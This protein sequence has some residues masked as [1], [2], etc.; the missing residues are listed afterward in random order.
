MIQYSLK[1]IGVV[2]RQG[3]M[4]SP[5]VFKIL[6]DRCMREIRAK[7]GN[8]VAELKIYGVGW[9][10]IACLSVCVMLRIWRRYEKII[11][12]KVIVYHYL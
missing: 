11:T 12:G 1:V 10:V 8:V 6:I 7:V 3:C 2:V 5:W 9:A 4:M